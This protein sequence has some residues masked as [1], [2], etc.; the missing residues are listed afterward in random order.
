MQHSLFACELPANISPWLNVDSNFLDLEEAVALFEQL[1]QE[2]NWQQPE[3]IV[4]GKSHKI[5]RWQDWQS[6]SG[7]TYQYSGKTLDSKPWHPAVLQLKN[8]IEQSTLLSFNSVLINFYRDGE[9]KMGWH[10]DN[11][12]ELGLNPAVACV[13]LGATR[14]IQFKEKVD[15]DNSSGAVNVALTNGSLLVMKPGMQAKFEH[16]IPVRRKVSQGRI[17]LTFRQIY[18]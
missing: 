18:K 4:F 5:P 8:K 17:S 9:D 2:L 7:V 3:V 10:S 6:D 16:Q 11:E 1:S 15:T 14:D 12:P 13:S